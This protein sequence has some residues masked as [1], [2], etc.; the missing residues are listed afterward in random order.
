MDRS[1]LGDSVRLLSYFLFLFGFSLRVSF[2][3]ISTTNEGRSAGQ[4]PNGRSLRDPSARKQR[5]RAVVSAAFLKMSCLDVTR[6]WQ[7]VNS[8]TERTSQKTAANKEREKK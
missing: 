2:A 3:F 6:G 5:R 7:T 8:F 4:L 1:A